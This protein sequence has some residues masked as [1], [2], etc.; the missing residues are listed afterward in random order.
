M[1]LTDTVQN[2]FWFHVS[3][4]DEIPI[5]GIVD[6]SLDVELLLKLINDLPE[7]NKI[8]QIKYLSDYLIKDSAT[9]IF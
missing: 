2:E 9:L 6:K 8:S 5:F 4:Q 1:K 7:S 3:N